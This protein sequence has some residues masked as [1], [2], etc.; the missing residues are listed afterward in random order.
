MGNFASWQ[1]ELLDL[2]FF[3]IGL[4]LKIVNV[5][6]FF[7]QQLMT[8]DIIVVV[9]FKG[10]EQEF[11]SSLDDEL[12]V[13]LIPLGFILNLNLPILNLKL[14]DHESNQLLLHF[15]LEFGEEI[16]LVRF[17]VK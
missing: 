14:F 9:F 6:L 2:Y 16:F 4:L 1:I 12:D 3:L 11:E 5:E 17:M 8:L 7:I 13:F 10:L 15:F